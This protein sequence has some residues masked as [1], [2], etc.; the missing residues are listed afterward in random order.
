MYAGTLLDIAMTH[1]ETLIEQAQA[2]E[3]KAIS[4]LVSLWYK[5]IYNF[6]YKYFGDHDLA[7]EATQKTFISMYQNIQSLR[8]TDTFRP[9]LYRIASNHCHSE[10]RTGFKTMTVSYSQN[11]ESDG[12][13]AHD[14]RDLDS[15]IQKNIHRSDLSD[16]LNQCLHQIPVEQREVL[17]MKEFEGLKFREIAEILNISENTVK[18]RLYYGLSQMRKVLKERNISKETTYYE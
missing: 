13:R 6:S 11:S 12:S 15:D 9:W 7:M 4:K 16:M 8:N 3:E 1:S 14:V 18:S 17:I 10:K 2:G 5:R